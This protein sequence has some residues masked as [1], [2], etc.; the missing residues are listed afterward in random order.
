MQHTFFHSFHSVCW[1]SL[2]LLGKLKGTN[3]FINTRLV[4]CC[5]VAVHYSSKVCCALNFERGIF[6]AV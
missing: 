2:G 5:N 3:D 4:G 1:G 6:K